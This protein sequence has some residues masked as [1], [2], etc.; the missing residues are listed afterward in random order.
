M[1]TARLLD[2]RFVGWS[3]ILS[4]IVDLVGTVFLILFF[5]LEAPQILQS[6]EPS[7]PPLFGTLNDA[8]FVLVALFLV[9]VALALHARERA[10]APA[11]SWITLAIGLASLLAIATTQVLYVPRLLSSVQQ[12]PLLTT[13]LGTMGLWLLLANALAWRGGTLPRGLSGLGIAVGL[14]LMLMPVT[15]FAAGG[16][17][18]VKDPSAGLSNPLVI[19]GFVLPMLGIGI[20]LP[21]WAILTGRFLLRESVHAR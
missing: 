15:Y 18:M 5:A 10:P 20:G 8:T 7:T 21:A 12:S 13:S 3:A 6:G 16:S 19:A 17:D 14:S 1:T 2:S 11:L 9:P 4:G